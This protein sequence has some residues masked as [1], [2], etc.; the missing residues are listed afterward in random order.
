[1]ST[2]RITQRSVGQQT[3]A[4]LQTNLARLG[5]LQQQLS[6]GK[7]LS[8]PSDSPTGTVSAMQFRSE[9][10]TNEQW[11]RNADD[12][13]GWLGTIDQTLTSSLGGVRRARDLTLQGLNSGAVSP[14]ARE[15]MA[16][17][18]DA[19]REGLIGAANTTYLGRPV[20]GGTTNGTAA[21]TPTGTYVGST[22]A[23][24]RTVGAGAAVRVEDNGPE[25]F[26]PPGADLFTV[27]TDIAANLRAG[28]DVALRAN[29]TSLD[30]AMLNVQNKLA[31]V[32]ARYN[33][34]DQMQ[35]AA[36]NR[37]VSLRGSLSQVEDIDLPKTIVDLQ[38]QQMAYEAALGA[39]QRIITPS[40]A[41]FL[42]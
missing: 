35:I 21:Y 23:V 38:M 22:T 9:I 26:G 19:L 8:K 31:D 33:R 1:M 36:D 14:A 40:L 18:V 32:G 27:L 41:D 12:A 25:V 10:R 17:E 34:V 13:K 24:T 29:L 7:V 2:F 11:S 5:N 4:G 20:F 6:S 42:R 16:A 28:N 39:T 30:A 37:V 3:L 15:A